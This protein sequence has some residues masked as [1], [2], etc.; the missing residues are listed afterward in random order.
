[1]IIVITVA[2]IISLVIFIRSKMTS[3]GKRWMALLKQH[4]TFSVKAREKYADMQFRYSGM[5]DENLKKLRETYGLETVAGSGSETERIVNLMKW[6]NRLTWHHPKPKLPGPYNAL[7]LIEVSKGWKRGISCW[8]YALILNE[9]YLSMGFASRLVHLEPASEADKE[10][11]F[12]TS[13][14]AK[15]LGKWIYM[16]PDMGGYFTDEAGNLL[17]ISE[18]R[19]RLI[20]GQPLLPN[21]DVK[22]FTMVLGK[23]SYAWYLSKNSFRYTCSQRSEFDQETTSKDKVYYELIPDGFEEELLLEPQTTAHGNKIIYVNDEN[24]FW[25]KP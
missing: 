23:G 19:R 12:V 3:T 1:M 11:H 10:S 18:I 2:I 13:V 8:M 15:E 21:R 4:A 14:F 6:V 7:H 9:V 22:G 24:L 16:D 25:Q 20:A 17:G 5:E